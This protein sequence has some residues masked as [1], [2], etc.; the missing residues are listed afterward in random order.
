MHFRITD[1]ADERDVREIYAHLKAYNLKHRELSQNVS[2]GVFLEDE[3]GRKLTGLTGESFG[4]W[5]CIQY[6]FVS[7]QLRGQGNGSRLLESAEKEAERRG[8]KYAF[9]DTFSLSGARILRK[10]WLLG[11]FRA[12]RLPL[13]RKKALLY[14]KSALRTLTQSAVRSKSPEA[15]QRKTSGLAWF[16][17]HS[18]AEGLFDVFCGAFSSV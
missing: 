16:Y 9:A 14:K 12:R 18:F 15:L 7:E 8:C 4:S 10:A 5:L 3:A 6:L 13:H 2:A 1:D 17:S 11:G